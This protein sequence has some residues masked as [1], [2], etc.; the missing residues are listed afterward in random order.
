MNFSIRNFVSNPSEPSLQD[1]YDGIDLLVNV[2]GDLKMRDLFETP[3]VEL[4]FD[5]QEAIEN[6]YKVG[7]F[8]MKNMCCCDKAKGK[9]EDTYDPDMWCNM[10]ASGYCSAGSR[11]C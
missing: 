5:I 1:L 2:A 7:I 3:K 11:M 8:G 4:E 10:T 9:C 6:A